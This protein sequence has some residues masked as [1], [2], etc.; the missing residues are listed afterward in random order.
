MI[1]DHRQTT[2]KIGVNGLLIIIPGPPLGKPRQTQ[3]DKWKKRPAVQKYRAW[4]D[5]ARLCAGVL[6]PPAI[7]ARL[8]WKAYFAPPPSWSKKAAAAAIGQLHRQKPDRDNIDKAVLDALFP[9]DSGIAAGTIAKFWDDVPRLEI[10]I[11][12]NP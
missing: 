10:T 9:E 3:R 7:I 1:I 8:D 2:K 5:L 6:P 12:V 4:A 11:T